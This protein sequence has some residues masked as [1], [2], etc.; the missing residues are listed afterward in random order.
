VSMVAMLKNNEC[1][2]FIKYHIGVIAVCNFNL[3]FPIN[4]QKFE[5]W[6]RMKI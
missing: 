6:W 3:K 2:C 5:N 4:R 1:S